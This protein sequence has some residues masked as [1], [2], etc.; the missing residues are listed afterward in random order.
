M[1]NEDIDITPTFNYDTGKVQVTDNADYSLLN[2]DTTAILGLGILTD[3]LSSTVF[4]RLTTAVPLVNLLGGAT[5]SSLFN[6]PLASDDAIVNGTY[7]M[8]YTVN[9]PYNYSLIHIDEILGV[10]DNSIVI[11]G[12]F[13]Y[14]AVGDDI[15]VSGSGTSNNGTY[16]IV[17]ITVASGSSASTEDDIYTIK[18]IGGTL[19]DEVNASLRLA[20]NVTRQ[21]SKTYTL[22]YS[23]CTQLVPD[24]A[25]TSDCDSGQYGTVT[26][27]DSTSLDGQSIV[28][29]VLQ[30]FRPSG[31]P[32]H[33]SGVTPSDP[34]VST[35][36]S[37]SSITSNKLATGTWTGKS[38][39]TYSITGDDGLVVTYSTTYPTNTIQGTVSCANGICELNNCISEFW[40]D[41]NGCGSPTDAQ[42]KQATKLGFLLAAYAAAKTCSETT[43]MNTYASAVSSVLGSGCGCGCTGSESSDL[44]AWVDNLGEVINECCTELIYS[45][46]GR[47]NTVAGYAAIGE[48]TIPHR[49][50]DTVGP[51]VQIELWAFGT[52]AA[53]TINIINANTGVTVYQWEI[54]TNYG[55]LTLWLN[56]LDGVTNR[57]ANIQI[58]QPSS[59]MVVYASST[60][61]IWDLNDDLVLTIQPSNT[62]QVVFNQ[63]IITGLSTSTATA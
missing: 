46:G 40:T 7:T 4:T 20:F 42:Y 52:D 30:L 32:D 56:Q 57:T 62:S 41:F 2:V 45:T 23:G 34:I 1:T 13:S 25:I 9:A 54:G 21:Y 47:V 29:R 14:L 31:L 18:V 22:P 49:W 17:Q 38:V 43:L 59:G 16:E 35:S 50:F 27:T 37:T 24:L 11:T 8:I 39:T 63:L 55:K 58:S 48:I 6:L 3:P 53:V 36:S 15:T 33:P 51:M 5:T 12:D 26:L 60:A 19:L 61:D 44:P 10:P 28:S